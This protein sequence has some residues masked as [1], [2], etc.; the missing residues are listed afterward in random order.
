LER[1]FCVQQIKPRI[2]ALVDPK[3]FHTVTSC[4]DCVHQ[5]AVRCQCYKRF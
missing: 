5:G 2:A 1:L 3:T 4:L